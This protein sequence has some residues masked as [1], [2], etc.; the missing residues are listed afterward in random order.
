MWNSKAISQAAAITIIVIIIIV[1][2]IAAWLAW[3]KGGPATTTTT[4]TTTTTLPSGGKIL[5]GMTVSLKGKYAHE[6]TLALRGVQI[7]IEWVNSHGGVVV[8]GKKYTL[9]LKYYDDESSSQRVPELYTKLISEDH[10]NFLLA[11]YS[12]GLTKAA[13]PIAENNKVLMISH[14]GA[15]DTIFQ[16]GYKYIV[17]TLSPATHYLKSVIDLLAA[18]NDPEIKIALIYEN[19]AFASTVAQGAKD[20]INAKGLNLVYEHAYEKGTKDF[21]SIINEAMSKGANV[22]IGGGHFEDGTALVKQAWQL[23]WKLKAIGIIVAPTLPEFHD[24]LKDAAENVMAPAQWEVG[25]SYSPSTAKKL[26]LEWYG[27]TN[28]EFVNMYKQK[29]NGE[30]PDYHAAEA[31]AS[32]L[33]LVKAIEAANSLDSTAVRNAFNNLDIMT[34]FGELKIDPA[35]GLQVNHQMIVVQW[36]NGVKKI[37]WPKEAAE[38]NPIYPASNWW[39][40]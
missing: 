4:T 10:V 29:F 27:P 37:V 25:V 22:L 2:A 14:G 13:A 26:G 40:R 38:A 34:F 30:V 24:Q 9:D 5:V 12:S 18:Q 16:Q 8:G 7:A 3:P 19:A 15:S 28:D 32:I 11:P 20:E 23:N 33:Y 21:S 35:T 31:A 6:G 39:N 17:Q 1:A 36:Q